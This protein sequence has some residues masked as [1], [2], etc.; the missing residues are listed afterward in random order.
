MCPVDRR[1]LD[2]NV[3]CSSNESCGHRGWNG[4]GVGVENVTSGMDLCKMQGSL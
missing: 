2:P 1:V 3:F 4:A